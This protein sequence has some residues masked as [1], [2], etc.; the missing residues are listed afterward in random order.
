MP[1][2]AGAR[3]HSNSWGGII[4]AYGYGSEPLTID[5]FVY[6]N[7]DMLIIFAAANAGSLGKNQINVACTAK[8]SLCVG[9]STD[10]MLYTDAV[11]NETTVAWFSGAM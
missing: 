6:D 7:P 8:N 10:R 2:A 1:Y 11:L 3:V 9:A 5:Q 4:P